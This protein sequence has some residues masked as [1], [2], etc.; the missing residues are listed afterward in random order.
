ME[1]WV[2]WRVWIFGEVELVRLWMFGEY[3]K[4]GIC[5]LDLSF[6]MRYTYEGDNC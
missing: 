5:K 1:G 4:R 2:M 6:R 3:G